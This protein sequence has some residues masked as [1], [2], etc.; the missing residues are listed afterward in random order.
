MIRRLSLFVA[1]VIIVLVAS[2]GWFKPA[3]AFEDNTGLQSMLVDVATG[4][5]VIGPTST[6][7]CRESAVYVVWGAGVSAGSVLIESAHDST[8]A[9]TWAAYSTVSW[10]AASKVDIVQITG[11]AY[12]LRTRI[13]TSIV[14]GTVRTYFVCN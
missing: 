7:K 2:M 13:G 6:T 11:V 3:R 1:L 8:Y 10:S 4:S 14:G 9:G 12:N 5:S